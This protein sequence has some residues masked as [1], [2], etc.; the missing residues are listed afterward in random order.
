[1]AYKAKNI[2]MF[3]ATGAIGKFI[4]QSLIDEKQSFGRIAI[5]TSQNTV[6][7][8]SEAIQRLKSE[9]VEIFVGDV[10][11]ET[12]LRNALE[13]KDPQGQT[14]KDSAPFDTVISA[15]GRN[16]IL[17]QIKVLEIAE[18]IPSV[19]RIFPSEY[20]T[21]IEYDAT[22]PPE[23]PHQLK[24]KVRG[25]INSSVKRLEYTYL[26]T[27]PYSDMYISKTGSDPRVGSFDVI[28]KEATVIEDGNGPVSF[29]SMTE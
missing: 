14:T 5:F 27:G 11:N 12:H 3:G 6:D 23:P 4:I 28:A 2:L 21:D 17:T 8:K 18:T 9:G 16:A 20:G 7:T 29:T 10:D 19:K 24:L 15:V 22:S 13:G 1:M 26:V 25:Y